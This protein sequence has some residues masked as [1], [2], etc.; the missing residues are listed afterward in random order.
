MRRYLVKSNPNQGIEA[1]SNIGHSGSGN[2]QNPN[3]G[4]GLGN[5]GSG[6]GNDEQ[7]PNTGSGSG[8]GGS[9]NEFNP[10]E[11]VCDPALRRQIASY[12]PDFQDQVRRAYIL[13]GPTQPIVKFPHV[14]GRKFSQSWFQ[15]YNWIEYSVSKDAAFCFFC[16]LFK[17]LEEANVLV[18]KSSPK[19]VLRI[20]NMH[21]KLYP[22]MLVVW[23]VITTIV[24]A[25]VMIL[26]IKTKVWQLNW[27][28]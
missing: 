27:L 25:I 26:R 5:T 4:S 22:N 18:M 11:I 2:D 1:S 19:P 16:F 24:F 8:L 12:A 21:I 20:G 9:R 7:S 28:E 13:K 23:E 10:D 15:R 3:T 14:D 17:I 6:S